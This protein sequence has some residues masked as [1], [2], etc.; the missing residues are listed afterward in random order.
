MDYYWIETEEGDTV[1]SLIPP[2]KSANE[3]L[4]SRN[5]LTQEAIERFTKADMKAFL[6]DFAKIL[7]AGTQEKLWEKYLSEYGLPGGIMPPE[8]ERVELEPP[9]VGEHIT[10]WVGTRL[11]EIAVM[12]PP[13]RYN[14]YT[15]DWVIP[16]TR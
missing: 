16:T 10:E 3:R 1:H 4:L 8:L 13:E 11:A 6:E 12:P 14:P 2:V 7:P 9:R 5:A 15:D